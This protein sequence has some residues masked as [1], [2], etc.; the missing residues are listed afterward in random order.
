MTTQKETE[1]GCAQLG[2][3]S[4]VCRPTINRYQARVRRYGNR[5]YEKA[6]P[7]RHSLKMASRDL[8]DAFLSNP[9]YKRGDIIAFDK[10][11]SI[12]G[13]MLLAEVTR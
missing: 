10:E 5:L 2:K 8:M 3:G 11:P 12:Y 4:W 13:P 7:Q 9:A 6:G 1:M